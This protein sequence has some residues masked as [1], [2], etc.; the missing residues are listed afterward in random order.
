MTFLTLLLNGIQWADKAVENL[1]LLDV[2]A[3]DLFR[4]GYQNLVNQL[5]QNLIVQFGDASVLADFIN[6]ILNLVQLIVFSTAFPLVLLNLLGQFSLFLS[7]PSKSD[8]KALELDVES[9]GST[10]SI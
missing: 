6:K 4:F 1:D 5:M 7:L 10:R 3:I 2:F 9:F 8:R